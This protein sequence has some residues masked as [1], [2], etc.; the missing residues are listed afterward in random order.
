MPINSKYF[1]ITMPLFETDICVLQEFIANEKIEGEL[2]EKY[3]ILYNFAADCI[4]SKSIQPELIKYLLPFYFK[5]IEQAVMYK[6]KIAIDIYCNFNSALFINQKNFM[7]AVGEKNYEY[8]MENY[9]KQIIKRMEEDNLRILDWIS[10][11]NTTVAFYKDNILL[12]FKKIFEGSLSIKYSF[13]KYLSVL[14]FKES[15]NLFV[16]GELEA[17]WTDNIWCFDSQV[18][19]DF[20]WSKDI[21][22]Y[23]NKEINQQRIEFLF[24]EVK[25]LLCNIIEFKL[26]DLVSEEINQSFITGIFYNRKAEYLQ[27]MNCKSGK[28]KCWDNY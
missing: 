12:L 7:Y 16:L 25:P 15:D 18:S 6:D 20:Y 11:F 17:Y 23:Y 21:I 19:D 13:L 4:Y 14:L 26:V 2:T 27:K 28:Y 9:I 5:V 10:L 8:I 24:K 3:L 22:E 1:K